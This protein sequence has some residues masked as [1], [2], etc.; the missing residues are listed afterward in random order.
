MGRRPR[1]FNHP[2]SFS[3]ST[4]CPLLR[5][6]FKALSFTGLSE[7]SFGSDGITVVLR[8]VVSVSDLPR[9]VAGSGVLLE[10]FSQTQISHFHGRHKLELSIV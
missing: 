1:T 9:Y 5:H 2:L 3:Q 7:G 10:T 8:S 4:T 6:N